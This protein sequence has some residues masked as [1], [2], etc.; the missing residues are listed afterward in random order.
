MKIHNTNHAIGLRLIAA[1]LGASLLVGCHSMGLYGTPYY[2][3]ALFQAHPPR[4]IAILPTTDQTG[5]PDLAPLMRNRL[6]AAFSLLPYGDR[7]IRAVDEFIATKAAGLG[8]APDRLP[9]ESLVDPKLADCVIYT[10]LGRVSRLYLLLYAHYCFDLNLVMV[11]THTRSVLYRNN[12]TFYDRLGTPGYITLPILSIYAFA[13]L[14]ESSVESLWHLRSGRLEETFEEG[15][16][17]IAKSIPLPNLIEMSSSGTIRLDKVQ[18]IKP[19][20]SLCAGQRVLVKVQG[21]TGCRATFNVGNVARGLPLQETSPGSYF[22]MY[23]IKP[24]DNASYAIVEV[25][26]ESPRGGDK[27]DY[28]ADND[29]FS[30]DTTAPP[31]ARVLSARQKIF[32]SGVFLSFELDPQDKIRANDKTLEYQV[33]RRIGNGKF[34]RIGVSDDLRFHDPDIESGQ[35]GEYYVVTRDAAGNVSPI[36]DTRHVKLD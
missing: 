13:G 21:S 11:D 30:I 23:A 8:V 3:A 26:L 17:E 35:S 29:P 33:Y 15:A 31:R 24:G 12:Y 19:F 16:K 7:E 28:A 36:W 18:V 9:P 32:R 6:I 20:T 10:Q 34:E 2:N 5:H 4:T 25:R 14:A 22:G 1:I 27:L